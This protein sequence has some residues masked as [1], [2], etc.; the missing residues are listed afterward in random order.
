MDNVLNFN[1]GVL[2]HVDS[3]KTSLSRV[4]STVG[5][6]ASFDKN[7]QSKERGITLDL[8]FSSFIVD[9][10]EHLSISGKNKDGL[11]FEKLQITLVDCPGHASLLKTIIGGAQIIDMMV[12]VVDVVKGMQ[13]QT[14]ECLIIGE[15]LCDKMIV[16]LNKV[17]LVEEKKRVAV[18]EKMKKRMLKTLA[19]TKF[20]NCPI[21]PVAAKIGGSETESSDSIG[22]DD[23]VTCLKAEAYIPSRDATGAFLFSVDHCFSIRGQGSVMTGTVLNG[24]VSV[25]DSIEI[26]ALKEVK[27]VKS[28]QMFRNSVKSITQGDRAGI[29]VTQFDPK[30]LER[31]LISSP[32]Y[33]LSIYG[34]ILKVHK[35]PYFKGIVKNGAKYHITVGHE[36]VMAKLQFFGP[37]RRKLNDDSANADEA[38]NEE[39]NYDLE[40]IYDDEL[41]EKTTLTK[42]K[43]HIL[44]YLILEFERPVICKQDALIIGSRL[45]TD[46]NLN[47][48]RL[49][50]HGRILK[51]FIS[52]DYTTTVLPLLKIYKDKSKE[53]IVERMNDEYTVI[54]KNLFKKETKIALFEN[55]KVELSTGDVGT[56]AGSFG[57]SGKIKVYI[58]NGLS[59]SSKETLSKLKPNKKSKDEN[60]VTPIEPV[61]VYLRFK[62]YIYDTH[63]KMIQN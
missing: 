15:I 29:C 11:S 3:G 5:S 51:A 31:G 32:D 45:D 61:Q 41:N 24:S 37:P 34:C 28:M 14:A 12:L 48:C 30:R 47:T 55:M 53:G 39:L 50:F 4:L 57:Q 10:P 62:K 20:A 6:T 8:G 17:D 19:N 27:K 59:E 36:T 44:Q 60:N 58:P 13:T 1:I 52:R 2:G 38:K 43:D 56:I 49:A 7:P 35:I 16:V 25:G 40:Y 18:I 33:L 46:V 9:F 21:I 23:L 26:P 54:V 63:H 42:Y 22:L